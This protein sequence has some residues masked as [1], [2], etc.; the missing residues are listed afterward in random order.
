MHPRKPRAPS[1]CNDEVVERWSLS[2]DAW[3]VQDG[4][5]PDFESGQRAEFAVEFY[6]PEPPELTD[7]VAPRVRLTDATSYEISG[8]VM[9]IVEKA[10]VLDCGIGVYQEQLPLSGIAVGDLVRGVANLEG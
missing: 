7:H 10:W 5:Y 4:N 1:Q 9:A 8:R 2:L 6:F 3:I